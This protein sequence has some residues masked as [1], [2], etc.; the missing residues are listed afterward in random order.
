MINILTIRLLVS[1]SCSWT[2]KLFW[3]ASPWICDQKSTIV[4]NKDIF[5]ILLAR[6]I[7]IY[8]RN[9]I[10]LNVAMELTYVKI[11]KNKGYTNAQ[12]IGIH[13]AYI[14]DNKLQELW[15]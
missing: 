15:R 1:C 11:N 3:F 6:L 12:I 7:D 9:K 14:S 8:K 13:F 10:F 2:T 5:Y 4:L